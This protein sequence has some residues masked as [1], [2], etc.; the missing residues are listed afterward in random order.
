MPFLKPPVST[1]KKRRVG[2]SEKYCRNV[3]CRNP[4][5]RL[6]LVRSLLALTSRSDWERL[7]PVA[8]KNDILFGGHRCRVF[9]SLSSTSRR[10]HGESAPSLELGAL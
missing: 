5:S 9:V 4:A 8:Y 2:R 6:V 3:E 10:Y 1:E 7:L